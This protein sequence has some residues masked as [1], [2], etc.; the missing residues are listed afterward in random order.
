MPT[1]INAYQ[2][3]CVVPRPPVPPTPIPKKTKYIKLK[4]IKQQN[5]SWCFPPC[6]VN[7]PAIRA[8]QD[9]YH[10]LW[11]HMMWPVSCCGKQPQMIPAGNPGSLSINHAVCVVFLAHS[12]SDTFVGI[13]PKLKQH[14]LTRVLIQP[15]PRLAVH[16]VSRGGI[17]HWN[18]HSAFKTHGTHEERPRE[19]NISPWW[20]AEGGT[21]HSRPVWIP[22][23]IWVCKHLPESLVSAML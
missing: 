9:N 3:S 11:L 16:C 21:Q 7:R 19:A 6:S 17:I 1:W 18:I 22:S 8:C 2:K 4:E 12:A 13:S 20:L 15:K 5:S 23:P 14:D 10:H